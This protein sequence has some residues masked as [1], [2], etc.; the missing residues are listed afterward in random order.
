MKDCQGQYLI[1]NGKGRDLR[2]AIQV[3][4]GQI[5]INVHKARPGYYIQQIGH[6]D[7]TE[8]IPKGPLANLGK[9]STIV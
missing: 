4:Q 2:F 5:K 7:S 6:A 9:N 3:S 1:Y 8:R